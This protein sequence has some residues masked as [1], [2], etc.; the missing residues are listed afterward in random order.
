MTR[1]FFKN[2]SVAVVINWN[3]RIMVSRQMRNPAF[4]TGEWWVG[5]NDMLD[6]VQ[7]I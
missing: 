2:V 6:G 7:S 5:Q 1:S 3:S 4:S